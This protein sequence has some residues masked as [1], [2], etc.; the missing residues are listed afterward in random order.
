MLSHNA[1]KTPVGFHR[2]FFFTLHCT[3][4]FESQVT[5]LLTTA[6][7]TENISI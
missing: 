4:W 5:H 6:L 1:K 7:S 2:K 3:V